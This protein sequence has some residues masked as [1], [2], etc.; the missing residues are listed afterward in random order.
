MKYSKHTNHNRLYKIF[1]AYILIA[2]LTQGCGEDFCNPGYDCRVDL[3]VFPNDFELNKGDTLSISITTDNTM[4][5][6]S[7]GDRIV[8]FPNFDPNLYFLLPRLDSTIH[9]DGFLYNEMVLNP[10]YG[11]SL[12]SVADHN[13]IGLFFL[14]I[15]TTALESKLDFQIVLQTE[16]TYGLQI[17]PSIYVSS[18]SIEFPN[19]CMYKNQRGDIDATIVV[20]GERHKHRDLLNAQELTNLDFHWD[21]RDGSERKSSSY[22]FKVVE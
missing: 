18:N 1:T 7:V 5:I 21:E 14:E 15:D 2:L 11:T 20:D 8:E 4:L 9:L 17:N 10:D 3:V 6:D 19:K 22:Y 16:G 13:S 12:V